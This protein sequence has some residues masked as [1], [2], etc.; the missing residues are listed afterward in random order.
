MVGVLLLLLLIRILKT[1]SSLLEIAVRLSHELAGVAFAPPVSA[2]YDPTT[3]AR[4]PYGRYLDRFG[5]PPKEVVLVGMNP[6]PWGMLQTGVPFGEVTLVR[7]WMG[8]EG[9][10][11][12][13]DRLHP[14]RPV[15]GFACARSE[16]SGRRL[17]GW[18]RGRFGSADRFFADFL[19]V[20]YCPLAFFDEAGKNI[21][22]DRLKAAG[23][24]DLFR[25]CDGATRRTVKLLAPEW[26]IGIGKFA[27]DRCVAALDGMD[28][29]VG[30][31]THPSPANPTANRG[32][33]EQVE[34]EL[35]DLGV[36]L[37]PTAGQRGY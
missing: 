22:P 12:K 26:V 37:P 30:R 32:W 5:S 18:A 20:N 24:S 14:R 11:E 4:E 33:V 36:R 28:V 23:R 16:V 27:Y 15:D 3:Y 17:W 8:I 10:V 9:K 34:R 29:K 25:L 1:M 2:V 6:G 7:E 13:P 35:N 21:T 31:V 19:V